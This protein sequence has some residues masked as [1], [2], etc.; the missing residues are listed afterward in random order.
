MALK[1]DQKAEKEQRM[2]EL[3][4]LIEEGAQTFLKQEY[5]YL[6]VFMLVFSIF[7]ALAVEKN[8]GELW[9]V[10]AFLIGGITSILSGFIG[11]KIAVKANVRTTK[12]CQFGLHEGFVVAFRGGSVLGFMLVGFGLLMLQLLLI[13]YIQAYPRGKNDAI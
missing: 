9:T 3:S 13:F 1:D 11:M 7:I 10:G 8:L 5:T 2:Q 6:G 4:T 12:Q